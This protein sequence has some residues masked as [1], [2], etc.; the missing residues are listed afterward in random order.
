LVGAHGGAG[1]TTLAAA[2]IG[3]DAGGQHWPRVNGAR[4]GVLIVCRA[5]SAGLVAAS[6]IGTAVQRRQVPPGMHVLG[7]IIVAAQPGRWPRIVRERA[8]LVGGWFP[9][10]WRVPWVPE[11]IA[12]TTQ[13]VRHSK[14][15]QSAIPAEL[16]TINDRGRTKK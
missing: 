7:L 9:Q 3:H 14:A 15:Y 11:V 16:F 5:S 10:A 6:H 13:E 8:A 2:G 1:T 12:M 4:I